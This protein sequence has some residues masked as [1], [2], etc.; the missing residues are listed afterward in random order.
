MNLI[1]TSTGIAEVLK[2]ETNENLRATL[3]EMQMPIVEYKEINVDD[4]GVYELP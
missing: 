3:D 4:Y 2:L 1:N